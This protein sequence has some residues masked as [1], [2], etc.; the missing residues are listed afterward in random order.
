MVVSLLC[1]L[2]TLAASLVVVGSVLAG[3]PDNSKY[4]SVVSPLKDVLMSSSTPSPQGTL[5]VTDAGNGGDY[6]VPV[7]LS[8]GTVGAG[9]N[10]G[11]NGFGTIRISPT[12]N[13]AY[14]G[15]DGDTIIPVA[16][17][18]NS[19]V[20]TEGITCSSPIFPC[21]GNPVSV[22]TGGIGG[23]AISPSGTTVYV[24]NGSNGV[25]PINT[26]GTSLCPYSTPCVKASI[27]APYPLQD[28]I[29]ITPDGNSLYA[30][31]STGA[32]T[33]GYV[34]P[35]ALN[36]NS[37]ISCASG[38]AY[39]CAGAAITVG[40][41]PDDIVVSPTGTSVWATNYN[42][43]TVS[44]ID[45]SSQSVS[46]TITN[47]SGPDGVDFSPNG[48]TGYVAASSSADVVAVN[49]STYATEW[50]SSVGST[51]TDDLTVSPD[52][53][54]IYA[55]QYQAGKVT[56][57]DAS[58]NTIATSPFAVGGTADAM[59]TT[60]VTE[61]IVPISLTNYDGNGC[62]CATI[63]K[64][65]HDPVNTATG[66]FTATYNTAS[67]PGPGIPISLPLTY[68]SN[69]ST[70]SGPFGPG[71]STSYSER[72]SLG[73]NSIYTVTGANGATSTYTPKNSSGN[74]PSGYYVPNLA[75][76][77][78][79]ASMLCSVLRESSGLAQGSASGS[80]NYT[81]IATNGSEDIFSSPSASPSGVLLYQQ[82]EQ[83][84]S[85]N[86]NSSMGPA[87]TLNWCTS[88]P[89]CSANSNTYPDGTLESVADSANRMAVFSYSDST[90]P[91]DVTS[92]AI[93][94]GVNWNFSYNA[95]GQLVSFTAPN[96]ATW[97]FSYTSAGQVAKA[98]TPSGTTAIT[99]NTT[100]GPLLGF[101]S[102]T[103]N[104]SGGT[105]TYDYSQY[106]PSTQTGV[107]K[108]TAAS[109]KI[110]L[111]TYVDGILYSTYNG[112][113]T[114]SE[115]VTVYPSRS[116]K[117]LPTST[118]APS[119]G[120][121]YTSYDSAGNATF[122]TNALGDVT[123]YKYTP[124]GQDWCTVDPV[125]YAS[126]S[127]CPASEPTSPPAPGATY[128][129]PGV[130]IS[131][132]D[133][134]GDLVGTTNALGDTTIYAYT[135][136]GLQVPSGLQYCTVGPVEY[137]A[138]VT[139]PTYGATHVQGTA[140]KTYDSMG[141][142]LTSTDPLGNSTHY[143]Y[144]FGVFGVPD[145]LRYC[146]V[147]P[148]EVANGATCPSSAPTTVASP[149]SDPYPGATITYYNSSGQVVGTTDPLGNT[150]INAYTLGV[151][152]VPS[153]LLYCS[154]DPANYASG[155]T[156]PGYGTTALGAS[157][158]TFDSNGDVLT[159]TTQGGATTTYA[160]ANAAFPSQLSS[161]VG[162]NGDTSTYTYNTSG[163]A[164]ES[165]VVTFG[166]NAA[167]QHYQAISVTAY[168]SSGRPYCTE[169]PYD[170]GL[171]ITFNPTTAAYPYN[172][173]SP[174]PTSA[175][176]PGTD[177]WQGAQVTIYNQV[178]QV[179]DTVSPIGG[180]TQYAYDAAGNK[181]CTVGP[182]AYANGKT[183]PSSPPTSP[184][185]QGS[186]PY[187]GATITISNSLDQPIQTT[188]PIGG[189]TLN[190]YDQAGN[191]T[192]TQV[193]PVSASSNASTVI[194]TYTYN[195]DNQQTSSTV[196]PGSSL[197]ATTE[198]FYD[199]SGNVYCSVSANAYIRGQYSSTNTSGY[200]CPAWQGSWGTSPP[201]PSNLYSSTPSS[202]QAN[203]VTTSFYDAN[204][205][206]VQTTN[207]NVDTTVTSYDAN[208]RPYCQIDPI[209]FAKG[210]T[211]PT[212]PPTSAPTTATGYT[213]TI[214]DAA[215]N[216]VSTTD[217]IGNTTTYTYSPT[218]LKLTA[219]TGAGSS[220]AQTT[221]YCY[222]YETTSCPNG[223]A[224][225]GSGAASMLYSIQLPS[226]EV[227][228]NTYFPGGSLE[229]KTNPAGTANYLYYA[230]SQLY[231][232]TYSS[233]ATGYTQ[234]PS[235]KKTYYQDGSLETVTDGTGTTTYTYDLAGDMLS[236]S[237]VP[238]STQP[239]GFT[240]NPQTISYTYYRPG[241]IAQ[242]V[243]P[244]YGS[245]TNPTATYAYDATGQMTSVTDWSGNKT[246]F[247]HDLNGNLASQVAPGGVSTTFSYDPSN[248]M[249][250]AVTDLGLFTS[251]IS[252]QVTTS[253]GSTK[254]TGSSTSTTPLT[255]K[256]M[257]GY[258]GTAKKP[259]TMSASTAT[260]TCTN[261]SATMTQNFSGGS[262]VAG[263]YNQDGQVT[264]YYQQYLTNCGNSLSL[265]RNYSY[266]QAGRLTYQGSAPQG[267][268]ANNFSY[269][270]S[271]NPTLVSS[272]DA[273]GNF[274]TYN[275]IFNSGGQVTSETPTTSTGGSYAYSY[276][277]I[278]ALSNSVSGG[279]NLSYGYN[280]IGQM[281]SYSFI[282][283][284]NYLYN[285]GGLESALSTG[286]ATTQF[287][288]G[289]LG[290]MPQLL[291]DSKDYFI[292]GPGTTPVE[293]YNVTT[294]PPSSNPTFLT[295]FKP[296]DSW[297]VTNTSGQVTNVAGY[298]AGGNLSNGSPG[299]IFGYQGQFQDTSSNTTGFINMRARWYD[300]QSGVFTSV[301]PAVSSTNQPYQFAN[302]DP[303]NN[304][305]PSGMVT[306]A[307]GAAN[308]SW[309]W[310]MAATQ[311]T[312][313][314]YVQGCIYWI[315][316]YEILNVNIS[317]LVAG[318][319][320]LWNQAA[321]FGL[322]LHGELKYSATYN[323]NP[324][325]DPSAL[326]HLCN[327]PS[328]VSQGINESCRIPYWHA[329]YYYGLLWWN[330]EC[331]V[332]CGAAW[333]VLQVVG[334]CSAYLPRG[335]A[336]CNRQGKLLPIMLNPG[337]RLG[338]VTLPTV[339]D[340]PVNAV[341]AGYKCA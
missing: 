76:T 60:S 252:P 336:H 64:R 282:S 318:G 159:S 110:D 285:A 53:S 307:C 13:T 31:S 202:T 158:K 341:G 249:T 58:G 254:K 228:T 326:T 315:G 153:G 224:P 222:Y 140:T 165:S 210:T 59:A 287:T 55:D 274:D 162:P 122:V 47:I 291:S 36:A 178:G 139:C 331:G 73:A 107:V 91:T 125:A 332:T 92:V 113:G 94:N 29:A 279:Y 246:T 250:Q 82:S 109:G 17:N 117:L 134:S 227:T 305:D 317:T 143:A 129:Y 174:P 299:T 195:A 300:T 185:T 77:P 244:S 119:G 4:S 63:Q 24:T 184:P 130:D 286:G 133:S 42:S 232:L 275:Q 294:S 264:Q 114:T 189:V 101:V 48:G 57:F 96:S 278:G 127:R 18:S 112:Y 321:I 273:A 339:T 137:Q 72:L 171:D 99:Y 81:L 260:S 12:G 197:A 247:S 219:T 6:L 296:S 167:Y 71:W 166:P 156:C 248:L 337:R 46:S 34:V 5:Y 238:P 95:S 229:T 35:I 251:G 80:T 154:V 157:T 302:G 218:G 340:G 258:F 14:V 50:S 330:N 52:G 207:P 308:T 216:T 280:T 85:L 176:A 98:S 188:D 69:E 209:N 266:D 192:E 2:A 27:S 30:V 271:N 240:L 203:N 319:G 40:N 84:A 44:V 283:A 141:N 338:T 208:G 303:V 62:S 108:V 262:P 329:G 123:Q 272:H 21:A 253:P 284:T 148:S 26:P 205:N 325:G 204:G 245:V 281:T 104:Q 131:Y 67:I 16:L 126:G 257:E 152:G 193:E 168:D 225:S 268:A 105:T 93:G 206:L 259:A 267:T 234:T 102:S 132:Y 312:S 199:P 215:G 15:T 136:S 304:S 161:K 135:P 187:P 111:D 196:D 231:T 194:T 288:W 324:A 149:N 270:A 79:G 145:G 237:Y 233:P 175:P 144:T 290:G 150:T 242:V 32:S 100:T 9:A 226:G 292:Y 276:N 265:Q 173:P 310:Y 1:C 235:V 49:T 297:L 221:T 316:G 293:Q 295:Y 214:Y 335:G 155:M 160:Y 169:A 118:T 11:S 334:G 138:G 298:D 19:W 164:I 124:G 106:D 277:S 213:T 263:S 170:V 182:L 10:M 66:N 256:T 327:T 23:I 39:P 220:A 183:C 212:S 217:P 147:S 25:I 163:Q 198:Q 103:T 8:T 38:S 314:A 89:S 68:N 41:G 313:A 87:T 51:N 323:S 3:A 75:N 306:L 201:T 33:P 7:S 177:P 88:S 261:S 241:N 311:Y 115:S 70:Q 269:D 20:N 322:G 22:G 120:V 128:S 289:N 255:T 191:L 230:N 309:T 320:L 86:T 83:Q 43:S 172:C 74:C 28:G 190:T 56:A 243:Y 61:P 65:T 301:D 180:V 236:Q 90:N 45:T 211:C 328:T 116:S 97:S 186:D 239:A 37:R 223:G 54:Q 78:S 142:V 333:R 179:A 151:S 146:Q 121:T 181:F 200:Q